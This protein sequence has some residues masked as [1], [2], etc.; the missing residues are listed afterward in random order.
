MV[1]FPISQKKFIK[2]KQN[3]KLISIYVDMETNRCIQFT[4][5]GKTMKIK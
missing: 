4:Y 1:E 5:Q 3:M 2:L